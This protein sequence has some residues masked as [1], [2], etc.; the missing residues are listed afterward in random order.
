LEWNPSTIA[1]YLWRDSQAIISEEMVSK[2]KLAGEYLA[3]CGYE[4]AGVKADGNCFFNAFLESYAMLSRKIPLLDVERNKIAY[5]R[6]TASRQYVSSPQGSKYSDRADT[7][8]KEGGWVTISEGGLLAKALSIPIRVI[9][10]N[11]GQVDAEVDDML[12]FPEYAKEN[13]RWAT[14]AAHAKTQEHIC[15]VDVGGHFLWAK[16]K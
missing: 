4:L 6:E 3:S 13:Q 7:I 8:K 14:L 9:T 16:Q 12:I 2:I 11:S 1:L 5:L 15:I 10:V